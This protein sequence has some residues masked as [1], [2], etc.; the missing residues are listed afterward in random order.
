MPLRHHLPRHP[1]PIPLPLICP[2]CRPA[3]PTLTEPKRFLHRRREPREPQRPPPE[4]PATPHPTPYDIFNIPR[5]APYTKTRY[6]ELAKLYH[7]DRHPHT[8]TH[9]HLSRATCTERYR[10]VVLANDILSDP[11]KRSA[12]DSHGA[13]WSPASR[14]PLTRETYRKWRAEAGSAAQNATWEDWEAWHDARNNGERQRPVYMSHGS[15][16]ALLAFAIS[17][18]IVGQANRAEAMANQRLKLMNNR[19]EQLMEGVDRRAAATAPMG[20]EE[21]VEWFVREREN[22]AFEFTP[23][24]WDK[25]SKD[26]SSESGSS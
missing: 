10:L 9:P 22:A 18:G 25:R 16:L 5:H 23:Q 3:S 19:Q 26:A 15:F 1:L 2:R 13:G 4:W 14:Q 24:K 11:S 17:I 20:K 7:P 8:T 6:Y 21:R 12:Y